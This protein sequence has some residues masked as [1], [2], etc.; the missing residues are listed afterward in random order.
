MVIS[1][2]V[3]HTVR[4]AHTSETCSHKTCSHKSYRENQNTNFIF[5]NVFFSEN[6]A[7]Y[8]IIWKYVIE[9]GRPQMT[10]RH[11][12]VACWIYKATDTHSGCVIR[13]AFPLQQWFHLRSS[14]L[15]C[16]MLPVCVLLRAHCC[17][18]LEF[19]FHSVY[20]RHI[21]RGLQI[22]SVGKRVQVGAIHPLRI[23]MHPLGICKVSDSRAD[24]PAKNR[25]TPN[26]I[27]VLPLLNHRAW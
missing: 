11:M 4:R 12:R 26:R 9:P 18:F 15:R 6:H 20:Q 14:M 3:L 10:I 24:W 13:I 8:E 5:R 27:H 25:A 7:F 19:F 17:V 21:F 23:W 22:R 2:S 16:T 1:F